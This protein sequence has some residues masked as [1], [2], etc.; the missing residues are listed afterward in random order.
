MTQTLFEKSQPEQ[1]AYSPP[2]EWPEL[3]KY[4]P[5][6]K[7]QRKE[8]LPLPEISELDLMRHYIGLSKRNM[9]IDTNFYPLGSCTMKYNPRI[10]EVCAKLPGF[11]KLHPLAP[12]HTV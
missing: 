6:K 10:N 12:D 9:G 1:H 2:K 5:E 8:E 4:V 3:K 7:L 11:S